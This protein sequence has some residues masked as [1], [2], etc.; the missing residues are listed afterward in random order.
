MRSGVS[1]A[2][3][4]DVA[5]HQALNDPDTRAEYIRRECWF[6]FHVDEGCRI[7]TTV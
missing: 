5:F 4:K 1:G 7:D 3:S 2:K 6:L